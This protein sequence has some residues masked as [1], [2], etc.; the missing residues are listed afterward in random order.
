MKYWIL[1]I[2][3]L[4]FVLLGVSGCLEGVAE[5]Q[6]LGPHGEQESVIGLKKTFEF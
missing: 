3:F 4:V 1:T 6:P 2:C 5:R